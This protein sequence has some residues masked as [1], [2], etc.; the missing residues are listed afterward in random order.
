MGEDPII[1]YGGRAEISRKLSKVGST[2]YLKQIHR[3]T[4]TKIYFPFYV[5]G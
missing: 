3:F 1:Y 4:L 2:F 5:S